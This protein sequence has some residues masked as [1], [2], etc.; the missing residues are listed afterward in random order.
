MRW[1]WAA[2]EGHIVTAEGDTYLTACGAEAS[3]E[4]ADV[5]E[6]KDIHERPFG[7]DTHKPDHLLAKQQAKL[8]P[9]DREAWARIA[10]QA[11]PKR[12]TAEERRAAIEGR[13]QAGDTATEPATAR[14]RSRGAA[15]VDGGDLDFPDEGGGLASAAGAVVVPPARKSRTN[16]SAADSEFDTD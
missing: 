13:K 11:P 14:A 15:L 6:A 5:R 4:D 2:G 3:H 8:E 10:V 7:V 12:P 9:D 1:I 16:R